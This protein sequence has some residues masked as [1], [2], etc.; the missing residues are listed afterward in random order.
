[1]L[2]HLGSRI[3]SDQTCKS[4][5][6][7]DLCAPVNYAASF[8]LCSDACLISETNWGMGSGS[9]SHAQS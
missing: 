4:G 6:E 2:D 8:H 1:M 3:S 9:V 5:I 7:W